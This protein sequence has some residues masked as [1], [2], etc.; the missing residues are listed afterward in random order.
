MITLVPLFQYRTY[1]TPMN[2]Q[3]QSLNY[4]SYWAENVGITEEFEYM[5]STYISIPFKREQLISL[6]LY[7]K[8]I[9]SSLVI[10]FQGELRTYQELKKYYRYYELVVY[11]SPKNTQSQRYYIEAIFKRDQMARINSF[12]NL[13]RLFFYFLLIFVFQ[14]YMN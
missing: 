14:S 2:S 10:K 8:Q 9:Q 13:G 1:Y 7:E 12:I 5:W 4:L 3:E 6:K 11:S